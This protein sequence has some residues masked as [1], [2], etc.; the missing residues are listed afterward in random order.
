[1]AIP[2]ISQQLG[3]ILVDYAEQVDD[4][5]AFNA[6][7]IAK[8]T[9]QDLKQTSPRDKRNVK[10]YAD[11]WAMKKSGKLG[12]IV[13][14]KT[15]WRLTHLLNNGHVIA[16]ASGTYGRT[17]GDNHIGKAEERANTRLIKEVIKKL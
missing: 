10:H 8:E 5:F 6:Q 9:V 11:G 16:N 15:S 14:N 12:Y 2:N 13:Y 4:T 17:Q 1:M 3:K 7:E